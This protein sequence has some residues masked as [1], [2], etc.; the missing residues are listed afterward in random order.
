[1]GEPFSKLSRDKKRSFGG[2]MPLLLNNGP[3]KQQLGVIRSGHRGDFLD[4]LPDW[5]ARDRSRSSS[6][7]LSNDDLDVCNRFGR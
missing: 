7:N 3:I 2:F 4:K 1:M 6:R 5:H